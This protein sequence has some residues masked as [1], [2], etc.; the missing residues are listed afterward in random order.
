MLVQLAACDGEIDARSVQQVI[1]P[2]QVPAAAPPPSP[3]PPLLLA[4]PP[5][6]DEQLADTQSKTGFSQAIHVLVWHCCSCDAHMVCRQ[7]TH[8]MEYPPSTVVEGQHAAA[9]HDQLAGAGAVVD[10]SSPTGVAESSPL[11]PP[12]VE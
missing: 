8:G 11:G 7:L 2:A 6:A 1:R 5:H 3:P 4:A 12:S 9:V 10:P